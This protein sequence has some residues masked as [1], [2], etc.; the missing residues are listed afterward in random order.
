M[1][2]GAL[3]LAVVWVFL[4][5]YV[6]DR[7]RV[8]PAA[9]LG[10]IGPSRA[11]LCAPSPRRRPSGVGVPAGV[12]P[13]GRVDPRRPHARPADP[14]HRRHP[15]GRERIALPPDPA[16]GPQRRVPRARRRLRRHA[17]PARGARRRAA[18]VRRQR[19]ARAAHP[20]G[21]HPDPARRRPQRPGPRHRRARRPPARRQHPGDRPH[22]GAAAAQPRRPAVLH[23][24]ARR[25]V[26]ARR[27]GHRDAPAPRREARRHHR[28]LR[29]R[30]P[31]HRLA[32]AAAADDHEPR[33]QRDRPQ[34]ARAGHACGSRPAC[35]P[36]PCAAHRREH[37]REA[38]PAAGRHARRAV[39]ARH[40][41][42]PHRPRRRRPRPGDRQEHRPGPRRHAHPHARAR[43][44]GSA[45][46]CNCQLP[47]PTPFGDRESRSRCRDAARPCSV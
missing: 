21:D 22:R 23:P 43:T 41:A 19:L 36:R 27:G 16:G 25:P 34:P 8:R 15:D 29:R 37:R 33:A 7:D 42:H 10:M 32:R 45:S 9:G 40:R 38:L 14:H 35:T 44:A 20:A 39:P 5:R 11:D 46:R 13:G 31:D 26:A 18:A 1:L 3:L 6:P 24:G 28:D 30:R 2:A 47:R 12:R 17:R 4:L